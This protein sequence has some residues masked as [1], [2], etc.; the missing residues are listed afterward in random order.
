[1]ITEWRWC[2]VVAAVMLLFACRPAVIAPPPAMKP[3][4]S[5]VPASVPPPQQPEAVK[6]ELHHREQVAAA[7]T[8]QGRKLLEAGQG[9]KAIRLFEQA[10]SQSPHYGP[11][12]YYLAESW[13]QKNNGTQARAFHDQAALYLQDQPTWRARL[14][15]QQKKIEQN[16]S[17]LV[18][19]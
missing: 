4:S 17:G 16:I 11:G 12:Y 9:D 6:D 15:R 8:D 5:G 2:G 10:L 14:D 18:I 3:P 1:M 7:L 13:L 19:P